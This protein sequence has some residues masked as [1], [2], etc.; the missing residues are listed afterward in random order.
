MCY[1]RWPGSGAIRLGQGEGLVNKALHVHLGR[2]LL[3]QTVD[4][5]RQDIEGASKQIKDLLVRGERPLNN[6]VEQILNRP[7]KFPNG[8]SP[9]QAPASLQG[10]EGAAE[11]DQGILLVL[12]LQPAGQIFRD[13]L[14]LFMGLFEE[15]LENFGTDLVMG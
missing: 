8:V 6:P 5:L 7:G 13:D 10:M 3:L 1:G 9:H 14:Q 4:Q 2:T 15:D 12:I 11:S